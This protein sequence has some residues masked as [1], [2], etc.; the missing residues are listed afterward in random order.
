MLQSQKKKFVPKKYKNKNSCQVSAKKGLDK[1]QQ[2]LIKA[3][4]S[5]FLKVLG[6]FKN[7]KTDHK[8]CENDKLFFKINLL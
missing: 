2:E 4:Q 1:T 8:H 6:H 7:L 3:M 5:Q